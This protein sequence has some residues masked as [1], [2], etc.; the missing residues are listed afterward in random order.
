[1]K[2]KYLAVLLS[3]IMCSSVFFTG[4]GKT[5][6]EPVIEEDEDDEDEEDEEEDNDDEEEGDKPFEREIVKEIDDKTLGIFSK[7]G[8]APWL[9][10]HCKVFGQLIEGGDVLD[11]ILA[12]APVFY[13]DNN[14]RLV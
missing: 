9:Y 14:G 11:R 10:G 8:G 3:A 13:L 2:K 1:M 4:C 6:D 12:L 5:A 7:Y